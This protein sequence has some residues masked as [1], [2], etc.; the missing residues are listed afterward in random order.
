MRKILIGMLAGQLLAVVSV[1][2]QNVNV[3]RYQLG[4]GL[5]GFVY[6][7][8]L[9]PNSAGSYST[10]RPALNLYGA[11][12]FSRSF[13]LRANLAL[14]ALRADEAVYDVPEYRAHRAFAFKTPL[15]E[16][17][18]LP[19][20]NILGKNY[21]SK[22]L[23]PYVFAG[24]GVSFLS[25]KRD[26]S[27]FDA[28]YFRDGSPVVAGLEADMQQKT[29]KAKLVIPLGLGLR[30]YFSDKWGIQ[31][32]SSYRITGTD[33]LDGFSQSVNPNKD[34][35]YHAHFLSVIYRIG[36]KDMLDCPPV[37]Y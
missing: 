12:L 29:P 11:R 26:W 19:E 3:P 6:M 33:Y 28:A 21:E 15:A 2:A 9:T 8:D 24:A 37:R 22:G 4:I 36:K 10:M 5:G 16:L 18:L 17:S 13:S 25:V 1:Y 32:E 30:Y 27:R 31:A 7:G 34:D 14:G 20:W 35:A 23:A